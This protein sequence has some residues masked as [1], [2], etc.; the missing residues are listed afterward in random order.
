MSNVKNK[1]LCALL[2]VFMVSFDVKAACLP[3]DCESLGY[4]AS[5]NDCEIYSGILYCPF[6]SSK[7][8]CGGDNGYIEEAEYIENIEDG[9]CS[10]YKFV[11]NNKVYGV[12][13]IEAAT[14]GIMI[15]EANSKCAELG[16]RLPTLSEALLFSRQFR[17]QKYNCSE[18]SPIFSSDTCKTSAGAD[19]HYIVN[20]VGESTCL[21]DGFYMPRAF[22]FKELSAGTRK[23]Y[24]EYRFVSNHT[25]YSVIQK[26]ETPAS[27]TSSN[28]AEICSQI[29]YRLPT[30]GEAMTFSTEIHTKRFNCAISSE[31]KNYPVLSSD[32]CKTSDGKNGHYAPNAPGSANCVADGT[33]FGR[34]FCIKKY[35]HTV[36]TQTISPNSECLVE[37]CDGYGKTAEECEGM[38]SIRCPFD[39]SKY[40]C[41]DKAYKYTCSGD[42]YKAPKGTTCS[43]K[44]AS[45]ECADG[46]IWSEENGCSCNSLYNKKCDASGLTGKGES[47]GGYYKECQCLP[48]YCPQ[49]D[50]S[51]SLCKIIANGTWQG[52]CNGQAC[53]SDGIW[54]IEIL[55]TNKT[56]V[57]SVQIKL[58][59]TTYVGS[60]S[61]RLF[62]NNTIPAGNYYVR[63]TGISVPAVSDVSV[64][65][66]GKCLANPQGTSSDVLV[67]L[68]PGDEISLR[69]SKCDSSSSYF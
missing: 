40:Y 53:N 34:V 67:Y 12:K 52:P 69:V 14:A 37:N 22:C 23:C 8:I 29:G 35:P 32:T 31:A 1:I 10:T 6:D 51:C 30:T 59:I 46:Y 68:K 9:D 47:C 7:V 20:P 54:K 64:P 44:Y 11:E 58:P 48:Y 26:I 33:V 2:L 49:D 15:G 57:S 24:P 13:T 17:T 19:G 43:G 4:T 42:G 3:A 41:C 55:N 65:I 45:C 39:T 56:V 25:M 5:I 61:E 63:V 36:L 38:P 62:F 27:I 16:Y 50:G 28:A 60:L 21:N 18:Q 66:I